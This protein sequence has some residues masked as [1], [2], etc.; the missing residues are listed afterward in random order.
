MYRMSEEET[1]SEDDLRHSFLKYF[2]RSRV[3][4][5]EDEKVTLRVQQEGTVDF[6][7]T[8]KRK[9]PLRKLMMAYCERRKLGDYRSLRFHLNGDRIT[10]DQTPNQLELENADVIDA[11]SDQM[12][13]APFSY[14]K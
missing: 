10:G 12:G 8:M 14:F 4:E 9:D 6:Y 7:F 3:K 13:G 2:C 11:W 5:E 1:E